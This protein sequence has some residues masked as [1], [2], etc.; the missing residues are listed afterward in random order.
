MSIE[1]A[2]YRMEHKLDEILGYVRNSSM[3]RQGDQQALQAV[4]NFVPQQ[5]NEPRVCPV[6][7]HIVTIGPDPKFDATG[8]LIATGLKRNCNCKVVTVK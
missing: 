3:A 2:I 6:C 8:A 4:T 1:E 5:A 7:T